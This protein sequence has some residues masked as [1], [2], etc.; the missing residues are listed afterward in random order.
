MTT[1]ISMP[2]VPPDGDNEKLT[3]RQKRLRRIQQLEAQLAQEKSRLNTADRKIR[4]GQ[5][6]VFGVY[7]EEVYK[8]A[9]EAGRKRIEDS[10]RKHLTGR[11]LDRA[12]E[13]I[14][15]LREEAG[16]PVGETTGSSE[17]DDKDGASFTGL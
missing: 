3:P 2:P 11:N 8:A 10:I 13:G 1:P 16:S 9:D 14:A 17:D 4:N 15:R 7:V 12:L 5:L 6:V